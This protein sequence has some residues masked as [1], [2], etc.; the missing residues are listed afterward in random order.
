MLIKILAGFTDGNRDS[1]YPEI[2][3]KEL[4][5][6]ISS[7]IKEWGKMKNWHFILFSKWKMKEKIQAVIH[8]F[9][10]IS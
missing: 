9:I 6:L 2:N 5:K 4:A 1:I 3:L 7:C 10:F 8:Y